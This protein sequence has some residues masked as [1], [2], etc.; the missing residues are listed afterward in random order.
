MKSDRH[1]IELVGEGSGDGFDLHANVKF[2]NDK[3][4]KIKVN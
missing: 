4:I 3:K 2:S 1:D